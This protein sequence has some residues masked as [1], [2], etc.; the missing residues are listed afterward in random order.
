MISFAAGS[1]AYGSDGGGQAPATPSLSSSARKSAGNGFVHCQKIKI[2]QRNYNGHHRGLYLCSLISFPTIQGINPKV[3]SLSWWSAIWFFYGIDF[4]LPDFIQQQCKFQ[5]RELCIH[6]TINCNNIAF[7]N[8]T[9][10]FGGRW[11]NITIYTRL[12]FHAIILKW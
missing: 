1:T 6:A 11:V 7:A 4:R 10:K 9:A 2:F 5:A 12:N 3:R 8:R